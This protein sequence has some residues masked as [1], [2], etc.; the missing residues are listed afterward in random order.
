MEAFITKITRYV[1]KILIKI[2]EIA[3]TVCSVI[4]IFR[5]TSH[6]YVKMQKTCNL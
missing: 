4:I 1:I 3:K 2:V 5:K 6:N